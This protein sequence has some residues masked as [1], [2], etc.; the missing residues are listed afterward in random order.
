MRILI[1]IVCVICALSTVSC[2]TNVIENPSS[3][4]KVVKV[5]PNQHKVV[6]IKGKRYYYWNGR[7]HKRTKRGYVVVKV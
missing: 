7:Y 2:A 5:A 3:S 6:I 4:V 1:V